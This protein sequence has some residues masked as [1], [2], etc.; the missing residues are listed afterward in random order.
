MYGAQYAFMSLHCIHASVFLLDEAI[1][2]DTATEPQI[3]AIYDSV[4]YR[5]PCGIVLH[6][7]CDLILWKAVGCTSDDVACVRMLE[8]PPLDMQ[9]IAMVYTGSQRNTSSIKNN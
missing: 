1:E 8:M 2:L 5:L 4:L 6:E 3:T 7:S 9:R